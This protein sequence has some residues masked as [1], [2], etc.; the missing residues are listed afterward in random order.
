M[1]DADKKTAIERLEGVLNEKDAKI[2]ELEQEVAKLEEE[3]AT[4]QWNWTKHRASEEP[5]I[6]PVPRLEIRW[7]KFDEHNWKATYCLVYRHFLGHAEYVP[8]GMTKIG[9]YGK[10][11]LLGDQV[12]LPF[13]DGAHI[14]HD[15]ATLNLPGFAVY[16][17]HVTE[18]KPHRKE[19]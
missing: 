3:Q 16:E 2:Y 17:D 18:L 1:D 4:A 5:E 11:P 13:R 9:G 10:K 7:S 12:A 6:L 19:R 8:L 14:T 15:M